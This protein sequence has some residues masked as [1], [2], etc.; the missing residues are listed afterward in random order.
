[1]FSTQSW[2]ALRKWTRNPFEDGS[3]QFRNKNSYHFPHRLIHFSKLAN[4]SHYICKCI[5]CY[6]YNFYLSAC[7]PLFF[8][9][10][11]IFTIS[12]YSNLLNLFLTHPWLLFPFFCSPQRQSSCYKTMKVSTAIQSRI[13]FWTIRKVPPCSSYVR[14]GGGSM[15]IASSL[16]TN[17]KSG[18]KKRT[19]LAISSPLSCRRPWRVRL[20]IA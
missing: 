19:T 9:L 13:V 2:W 3:N 6:A 7:F 1:M 10:P 20:G 4:L 8:L 5:N 11:Q 16:C 18:T 17:L 14:N 15:A 12:T